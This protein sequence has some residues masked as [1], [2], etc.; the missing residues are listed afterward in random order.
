MEGRKE[1]KERRKE[2]KKAF[3]R[4]ALRVGTEMQSQER[5]AP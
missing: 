4:G 1:G 5:V 3:I 2:G